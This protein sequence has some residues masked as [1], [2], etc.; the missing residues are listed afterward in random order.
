MLDLAIVLFITFLITGLMGIVFDGVELFFQNNLFIVVLIISALLII[1]SVI[2]YR[3]EKS[4]LASI[5]FATTMI[6]AS[7][8]MICLLI[9]AFDELAIL[10]GA[11]LLLVGWLLI[12]LELLVYGI[13]LAIILLFAV[14]LPI[15]Y[16]SA[17]KNQI[18]LKTVFVILS[19]VVA[20]GFIHIAKNCSGWEYMVNSY[21]HLIS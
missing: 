3:N 11:I 8:L 9:E 4:M 2:I 21:N 7:I 17:G 1:I 6:P 20:V 19:I 12:P 14:G 18:A 13:L 10:D 16:L 5:M 15:L